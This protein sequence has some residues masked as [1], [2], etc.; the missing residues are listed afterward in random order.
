MDRH[1]LALGRRVVDPGL[2][3]GLMLLSGAAFQVERIGDAVG[4]DDAEIRA[5]E[6]I[7]LLHPARAI[8]AHETEALGVLARISVVNVEVD[9]CALPVCVHARNLR[10]GQ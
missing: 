4:P 7:A 3:F 6:G 10:R 9:P 5:G 8:D 1:G 2:D